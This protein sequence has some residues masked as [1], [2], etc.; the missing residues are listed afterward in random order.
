MLDQRE[1]I[2]AL[3]KGEPF[4]S[5][6][7]GVQN[8][9][10]WK[11]TAVRRGCGGLYLRGTGLRRRASDD[12]HGLSW[13]ARKEQHRPTRHD[14]CWGSG[15]LHRFSLWHER[16]QFNLELQLQLLRC[17]QR[18][19]R[20]GKWISEPDELVFCEPRFRTDD[21]NSDPGVWAH[22]GTLQRKRLRCTHHCG[23]HGRRRINGT[24]R[25]LAALGRHYRHHSS[26]RALH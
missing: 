15:N 23:R 5:D 14:E 13:F 25:L 7:E 22:D 18:A 4:G 19:F 8:A 20:Y 10:L 12:H 3:G 16:F 2:D 21:F 26:Q 24:S 1:L 17:K 6:R 11:Q 9:V